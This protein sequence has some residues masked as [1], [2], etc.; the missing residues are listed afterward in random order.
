M[1]VMQSKSIPRGMT[2]LE[3]L[4]AVTILVVVLGMLFPAF[5]IA[6]D[7]MYDGTIQSELDAKAAMIADE[8]AVNLQQAVGHIS[9]TV[10]GQKVLQSLIIIPNSYN[11]NF[12]QCL[13]YDTNTGNVKLGANLDLAS[14]D[15]FSV[16]GAQVTYQYV[17][18][19][20]GGT[21]K[22]CIGAYINNSLHHILTDQ[23]APAYNDPATG[24]P[25]IP[26][27]LNFAQTNKGYQIQVTIQ[28][29][30]QKQFLANPTAANPAQY[31]M[32]GSATVTVVP[33]IP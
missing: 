2:L 18:L 27:G 31:T 17:Q 11:I 29:V 30:N 7:T 16:P 5:M 19:T 28:Q 15:Q 9:T 32:Y 10:N 25:V 23:L 26:L 3:T 22:H 14:A 13:G 24:L 21:V 12:Q 33:Q 20:E 6:S 1:M 4:L 8:L